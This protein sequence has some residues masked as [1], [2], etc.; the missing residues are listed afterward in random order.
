MVRPPRKKPF[1][2]WALLLLVLCSALVVSYLVFSPVSPPSLPVPAEVQDPPLQP[3]EV[4]LYF[5]AED[6]THLVTETREL[7]DCPDEQECQRATVQALL[8]GPVGLLGPILPAHTTLRG[9]SV[10][11][12]VVTVDFD[13]E[14][15]SGHP[16]GS[17]SELLTVYGLADT[18]AANFPALRQ[19][20]ILVEGEPVESLKGHVDLRQPVAADFT[21]ARP[22][23]GLGVVPTAAAA[24][25]GQP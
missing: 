6:A 7:A 19:L 16:G 25:G 1:W 5:A 24:T 8:D 15:I 9:I 3:R 17:I 21:F 11:D 22:S 20:R 14:L 12:G 23:A 18:L 13:T 10:A 2:P 4:I